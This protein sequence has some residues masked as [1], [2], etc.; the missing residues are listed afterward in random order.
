MLKQYFEGKELKK[1]MG[2]HPCEKFPQ[3]KL[4]WEYTLYCN[5]RRSESS[6]ALEEEAE[7]RIHR[8]LCYDI[9]ASLSW[10]ITL[11]YIINYPFLLRNINK[12]SIFYMRPA[13]FVFSSNVARVSQRVEHPCFS[14]WDVYQKR[15]SCSND[16]DCRFLLRKSYQNGRRFDI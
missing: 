12:L 5:R 3:E 10:W 9:F 1:A 6:M 16:L 4:Q 11:F 14:S 13:V 2:N 15:S 7:E 8:L